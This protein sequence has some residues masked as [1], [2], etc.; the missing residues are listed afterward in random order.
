MT[1]S[2]FLQQLRTQ[3]NSI[4][5]AQTMDVVAEHY[6][7]TATRF[8]NGLNDDAVVNEAGTNE[9]SCKLFAFAQ[10]QRLSAAETLSCFGTYYRDDV[11]GNPDG[12]DHAN[13]RNFM[14]YGW[15]GIAFDS[16][17]LSKV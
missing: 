2:E 12:S 4:E 7:Y 14:K 16:P 10:D 8:T 17:A 6:T 3:P 15:E 1:I 11:L 5:F 9:G 13:I